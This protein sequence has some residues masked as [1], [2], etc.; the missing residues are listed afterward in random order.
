MCFDQAVQVLG[1][2]VKDTIHYYLEKR[3][4]RKHEISAR[5]EDVENALTYLFGQGAKS[6]MVLTLSRLCEEYSLPLEL[7]YASSSS[8]RLRQLID[9]ILVDKLLPKHYRKRLDSDAYE[10]KL[11]TYAPWSD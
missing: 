4:I 9:R 3:H 5:F 10:D 11:G 2:G 6:I 1:L 7:E 8:E